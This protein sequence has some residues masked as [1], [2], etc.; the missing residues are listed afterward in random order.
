MQHQQQQWQEW[1]LCSPADGGEL[2]RPADA[3]TGVASLRQWAVGSS[4]EPVK[5]NVHTG[6]CRRV[7]EECAL[8]AGKHAAAAAAAAALSRAG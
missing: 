5:E 1:Q 3:S 7:E 2:W 8:V 4:R 6:S